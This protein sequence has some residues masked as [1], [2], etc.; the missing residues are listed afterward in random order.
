MD[1]SKDKLEELNRYLN[2][3]RIIKYLDYCGKEVLV[4]FLISLGF[5]QNPRCIELVGDNTIYLNEDKTFNFGLPPKSPDIKTITEIL[6]IHNIE[7]KR[8]IIDFSLNKAYKGMCIVDTNNYPITPLRF[9]REHALLL[10]GNNK[11]FVVDINGNE[12]KGIKKVFLADYSFK[13]ITEKIIMTVS[14]IEDK[15]GIKNLKVIK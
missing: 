12:Y 11:S 3:N 2:N 8:T 15:L 1:I 9:T 13:E 6:N 10:C 4:S 7:F 14:E 5:R